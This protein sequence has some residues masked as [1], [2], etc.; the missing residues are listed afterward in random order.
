VTNKHV[1]ALVVLCA[2]LI[3]PVASA[4]PLTPDYAK[5]GVKVGDVAIYRLIS[6]SPQNKS[7]LLVYGILGTVVTFNITYYNSDGSVFSRGQFTINIKTGAG[8][9]YWLTAADLT[10]GDPVYSGWASGSIGETIQMMVAGALR[11]I[12]H[13]SLG[14]IYD[15]YWDRITG[16][17]TGYYQSG[18]GNYTL[19]STTAWAP[20]TV[21]SLLN[22][23]TIVLVEGLVIIILVV[24]LIGVAS[25][26]KRR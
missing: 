1:S 7:Q 26:R 18:S 21:P 3:V 19:L 20:D 16:L 9:A 4:S 5:V 25:R 11:T 6:S 13:G 23:T 14:D 24:V 17:V 12:N 15:V 2:L 8:A 22:M 10:T